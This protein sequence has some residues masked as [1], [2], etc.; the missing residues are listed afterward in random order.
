MTIST[1]GGTE[2]RKGNT[3]HL[4]TNGESQVFTT[5]GTFITR[6]EELLESLGI[7][8]AAYIKLDSTTQTH[9]LGAFLDNAAFSDAH[10]HYLVHILATDAAP[11][12]SIIDLP[13]S[14]DALAATFAD[15]DSFI[16]GFQNGRELIALISV[17][18][19]NVENKGVD[20][21]AKVAAAKKQLERELGIAS[22]AADNNDVAVGVEGETKIVVRSIGGGGGDFSGPWTPRTLREAV[23]RFQESTLKHPV[24]VRAIATKYNTLCDYQAATME[25]S[26]RPPDYESTGAHRYAQTLLDAYLGYKGLLREIALAQSHVIAGRC[27][28]VA[29]AASE[30]QVLA[31]RAKTFNQDL[32]VAT[33]SSQSKGPPIG[34]ANVSSNSAQPPPYATSSGAVPDESVSGSPIPTVPVQ[35]MSLNALEPYSPSIVGLDHAKRDCEREMRRIVYEIDLVKKDPATAAVENLDSRWWAYLSP[36]MF[37]MLLPT[38]TAKE[39]TPRTDWTPF[40]L[41]NPVRFI[42]VAS[43]KTMDYDCIFPR[44]FP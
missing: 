27:C 44:L 21:K 14:R 18:L 42:A 22:G 7:P 9:P 38:T 12:A 40:A 1:V 32:A 26:I 29:A 17:K 8:P 20:V 34:T 19:H 4:A 36:T 5:V 13:T 6:F 30:L 39:N 11:P 41:K 24:P 35:S 25:H 15:S 3:P 23:A 31:E 16:S 33:T 43:G 10:V 28:L 37:R 2:R